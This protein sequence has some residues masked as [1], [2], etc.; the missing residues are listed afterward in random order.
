MNKYDLSKIVDSLK[1]GYLIVYP[2]DTLYG[3]GAD[4]YNQEAVKNVFKIKKRSF[5]NPLSVA[6]SNKKDIIKLAYV[7]DTAEQLIE[8]FLPGSLTL[9]LKKKENCSDILTAGKEKVGIRIPDNEFTLKLLDRFGPLTAT[10][11]N[12]HGYDT[13]SDIKNIKKMLNSEKIKYYIDEGS[14]KGIAST[15]VDVSFNKVNILREGAISKKNI[16]DVI[17]TQ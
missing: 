11:A 5:S 12:I 14:L 2:T 3:L 4:I 1:N 8:K 7:N 15:I 6:V 10:S 16:L 17:K 13:P 9:I